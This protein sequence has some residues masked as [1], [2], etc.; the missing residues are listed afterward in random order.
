MKN[1][2]YLKKFYKKKL[3]D[4]GIIDYDQETISLL[5]YS[6]KKSNIEI[7]TENN[8]LVS[9]NHLIQID[10]FISK[11]IKGIPLAYITNER[12]FFNEKFY[13]NENVLIPRFETEELVKK[14]IDFYKD[15]KIKGKRLLDI[16]TGSGVIPIILE[17]KIPNLEFYALDKSSKAIEVAKKN[18]FTHQS[19]INLINDEIKNSKLNSI[20][21]VLSNPPYIKTANLS[22]LPI[23]VKN[24]PSLALDG[25]KNGIEVIKEIFE[26]ESEINKNNA[27][28]ILIEI[29]R[30][31]Y[32][33]T[34][35][36]TDKYYPNKKT[37]FIKDLN[38][39]IRF[40]SIT[41]F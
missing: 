29:D 24:E 38:S 28:Y 22:N 19:K 5:S 39:N 13:V 30:Q 8:F 7:I 36:L 9:E 21:F 32:E 14:F 35:N 17:K 26:W 41:E 4:A 6:L 27:S 16:G 3:M 11:R 18:I 34:K 15:S 40:I 31:I 20:D 23:D 37:T 12:V 10:K 33:E 25:G 2:A 1:L